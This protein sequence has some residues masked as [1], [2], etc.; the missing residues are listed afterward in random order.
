MLGIGRPNKK[1]HWGVCGKHPV[2]RDYFKISKP[3]P[4]F[5]AL[6]N[7]VQRGYAEV[8]KRPGHD[9][10]VCSWRFWAKGVKKE[11]ITGIVKDSCDTMGRPFPLLILGTGFL[12]GW[13]R[14]WEC[15]PVFFEKLWESLEYLTARRLNGLHDLEN[16]ILSIK[17]PEN[18]PE[19]FLVIKDTLN[20]IPPVSA[21]ENTM[22]QPFDAI[23]KE[24]MAILHMDERA[25]A[26]YSSR[27][28]AWSALSKTYAEAAPNAV[29]V[30][31]TEKKHYLALFRRPIN[32][33]DFV[34]L[35]SV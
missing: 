26:V 2:A 11:L 3:L 7:W 34:R 14:C 15:L 12:D 32:T 8:L 5:D 29:F 4:A 35:W 16:A 19:R 1:W 30:G 21:A 13:E 27:A 10:A 23:L 25:G 17:M 28:G 9:A 22:Q 31:G 6:E 33:A 24:K 18:D 20:R